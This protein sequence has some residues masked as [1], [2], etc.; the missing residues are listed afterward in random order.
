MLTKMTVLN[1][2][3]AL[4]VGCE[5]HVTNLSWDHCDCIIH[6]VVTTNQF[7]QVCRGKWKSAIKAVSYRHAGVGGGKSPCPWRSGQLAGA[8]ANSCR[9]ED[10]AV[11]CDPY[12]EGIK[13]SV[14][15]A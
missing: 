6:T 9:H 11:N 4:M 3:T 5:E 15:A 2:T 12:T 13:E 7:L 14:L 1:G 10:L 8:D